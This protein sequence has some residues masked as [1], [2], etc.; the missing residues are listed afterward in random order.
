MNSPK[1]QHKSDSNTFTVGGDAPMRAI[2]FRAT[3]F[4]AILVISRRVKRHESQTGEGGGGGGG[5]SS[6]R[7]SCGAP[8][9]PAAAAAHLRSR[10][11]GTGSG[12]PVR[13]DGTMSTRD[14]GGAQN[15]QTDLF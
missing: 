5:T 3:L 11:S 7:T 14:T 1:K 4:S 13:T 9:T 8:G 2:K 15:K 6:Y 10:F 12:G